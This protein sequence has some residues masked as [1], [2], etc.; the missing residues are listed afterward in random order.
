MPLVPRAYI[1][2]FSISFS[3]LTIGASEVSSTVRA[4]KGKRSRADCTVG[5]GGFFFIDAWIELADCLNE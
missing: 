5:S 2:L 4:L 1:D 3:R